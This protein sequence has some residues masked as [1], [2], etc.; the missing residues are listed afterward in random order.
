MFFRV[1]TGPKTTEATENIYCKKG[2]GKVDY[3]KVNKVFKKFRSGYENFDVRSSSGRHKSI[4]SHIIH[5]VIKTI[6]VKVSVELDILKSSVVYHL[7]K[8]GKS[9]RRCRMFLTLQKYR[10][11]FVFCVL[12]VFSK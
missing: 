10:K 7:Y 4:H 2:E 3:S 6:S 9:I 5:Q 12:N 1:R 11:T 8:L